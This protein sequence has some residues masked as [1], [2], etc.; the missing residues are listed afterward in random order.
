MVDG[1][2]DSH[3]EGSTAYVTTGISTV[4]VMMKPLATG[5]GRGESRDNPLN[6]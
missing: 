6:Y 4:T 1:S 2:A 3:Y 5:V